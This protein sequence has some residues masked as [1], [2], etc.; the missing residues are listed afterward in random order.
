MLNG[1]VR[2]QVDY[3]GSV[4]FTYLKKGMK[5]NR[6]GSVNVPKFNLEITLVEVNPLNKIKFSQLTDFDNNDLIDFDN[7]DLIGYHE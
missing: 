1:A 3:L 5:V 7:N 6:L 2:L 4:Y